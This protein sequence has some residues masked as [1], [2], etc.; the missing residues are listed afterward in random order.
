MTLSITFSGGI[1]HEGDL[2]VKKQLELTAK[3]AALVKAAVEVNAGGGSGQV[4]VGDTRMSI[5]ASSG[6]RL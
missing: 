2:P 3:I 1:S 6:Y 4:V 5:N